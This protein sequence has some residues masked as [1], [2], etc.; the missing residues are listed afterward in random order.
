MSFIVKD[1]STESFFEVDLP[2]FISNDYSWTLIRLLGHILRVAEERFGER[3]HSYTILGIEFA[4]SGPQ[5]WYPGNCKHI[6]I[7]LG[8]K[9][10]NEKYRAYYQLAHESI[11]LLSPTGGRNATV[12]EEGLA[13]Y[14]SSWY[15]DEFFNQNWYSSMVSYT[16]ACADVKKLLELDKDAIQK[17]REEEPV[18]SKISS[19]LLLKYYPAL[20]E[21]IA[22]RLVQPFNRE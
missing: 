17:L 8:I 16:E 21:E 13:T 6:A 10:L 12:L 4:K 15:L 11:H 20:G 5:I 14:F 9:C 2:L 3:D 7:Q 19:Q 18:I 22:E 1:E